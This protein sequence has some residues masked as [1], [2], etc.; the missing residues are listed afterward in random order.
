MNV[1]ILGIDVD[2]HAVFDKVEN[3]LDSA[4][5]NLPKVV[6]GVKAAVGVARVIAIPLLAKEN[7][8]AG[9][10]FAA[11]IDKAQDALDKYT[12]EQAQAKVD[13]Q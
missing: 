12:E 13:G 10:L 7:P 2:V 11:A 5:Q 1:K 9:A 8:I 4:E 3:A 6:R